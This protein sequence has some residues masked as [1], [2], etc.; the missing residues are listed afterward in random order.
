MGELNLTVE[1]ARSLMPEITSSI[2]DEGV[3]KIINNLDVLAT[4]FVDAVLFDDEFI[5]NIAY[6]RGSNSG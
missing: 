3:E 2:D 4:A 6:N 5:V 1:E